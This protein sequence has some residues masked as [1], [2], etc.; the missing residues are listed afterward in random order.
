MWASIIESSLCGTLRC[1][2]LLLTFLGVS[3]QW[4]S[5]WQ[6]H[7]ENWY[8]ATVLDCESIHIGYFLPI[9]HEY[10]ALVHCKAIQVTAEWWQ[11]FNTVAIGPTIV[12]SFQG[13]KIST[14]MQKTLN[15]SAEICECKAKRLHRK[16]SIN[17]VLIFLC[18]VLS[19]VYDINDHEQN[20]P[21]F[22]LCRRW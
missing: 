15:M 3:V 4:G 17:I 21:K 8:C 12:A 9:M 19:D 1:R 13:F 22:S 6:V 5:Y 7:K 11:V 20:L 18:W 16:A 10:G 14:Y 2:V